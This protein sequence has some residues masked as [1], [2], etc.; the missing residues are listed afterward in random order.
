MKLKVG[1]IIKKGDFEKY[2][3]TVTKCRREP[4]NR[5]PYPGEKVFFDPAC[6][7]SRKKFK[8]DYPQN[9]VVYSIEEADVIIPGSSFREVGY[10]SWLFS[11]GSRWNSPD[12][13][14]RKLEEHMVEGANTYLVRYEMC[15]TTKPLIHQNAIKL[16]STFTRVMTEEERR[17]IGSYVA[18]TDKEMEALGYSLLLNF[19]P[20]INEESFVLI[21]ARASMYNCPKTRTF[22][23]I[24]S[25]LKQKYRNL[26]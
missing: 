26:K 25:K 3:E 9:P 22:R 24:R 2:Y 16:S 13:A 4:V 6:K 5:A 20:E 23:H 12:I 17:S 21:L 1:D 15:T 8:E 7:V 14:E 10:I 18:S 11:S 19:D